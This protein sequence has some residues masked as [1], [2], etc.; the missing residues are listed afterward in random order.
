MRAAVLALLLAA[1]AMAQEAVI[2]SPID[3]SQTVL[4]DIEEE[5]APVRALD[6]SGAALRG[7]DKVSG[8]VTD[9]ELGVGD[10]AALGRIGVTLG[11]CRYPEDNQAGEAFAWV[12]VTDPRREA[13]LFEG[14]MTATSPAL[15]ALDHPRYDVWVIRCTNA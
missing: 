2:T 15:N 13:P 7:L 8:E 10:S 3:G 12:T 14:W 1:P 4:Q 5:S 6:G 9:I 11:A